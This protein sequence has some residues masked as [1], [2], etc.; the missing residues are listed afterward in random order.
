MKSHWANEIWDWTKSILI[1]FVIAYLIRYFLFE[2][3]VVIGPSM[4]PTLY[5]GEQLITNKAVYLLRKPQR[6]EIVILRYPADPSQYFIKRVIAIE[7]DQIEIINGQVYVNDE[8]LHEPYIKEP[9]YKGFPKKAVPADTVFVLGD[10]R[11]NSEDSR[12]PSVGFVPLSHIPGKAAL[13]VYPFNRF[14]T[15]SP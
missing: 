7:G 4:M 13:R 10:N 14:G 5:S 12:F 6:G 1:A 8:L 11:N 2:R 15:V 3:T 9:P